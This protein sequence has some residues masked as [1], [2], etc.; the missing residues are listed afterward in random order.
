[1]LSLAVGNDG[2]ATRHLVDNVAFRW[3]RN[4]R[5]PLRW[6]SECVY[7]E[8]KA[9]VDNTSIHPSRVTN[10]YHGT[11]AIGISVPVANSAIAT[12][13]PANT[14]CGFS[15]QS[16]DRGQALTPHPAPTATGRP[17]GPHHLWD[18]A[19]AAYTGGCKP[20]ARPPSDGTSQSHYRVKT[21]TRRF[22]RELDQQLSRLQQSA[23][24]DA[25]RVTV[26]DDQPQSQ[27]AINQ[28]RTVKP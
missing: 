15:A 12:M 18:E 19:E 25:R 24:A 17:T 21:S 8:D 2:I 4:Q 28:S 3:L 6:V 9:Q 23:I 7:D 16:P 13:I 20:E 14:R 1:M 11:L 5:I 10:D 26:V 27:S 22:P